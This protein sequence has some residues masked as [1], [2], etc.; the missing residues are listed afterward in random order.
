[1]TQCVKLRA[2]SLIDGRR[3]APIKKVRPTHTLRFASPA[4]IRFGETAINASKMQL[5]IFVCALVFCAN[6]LLAAV[7]RE[8]APRLAKI[9]IFDLD[10]TL[11]H[12]STQVDRCFTLAIASF[13][14]CHSH[15]P[16]DNWVL[17]ATRFLTETLPR[18]NDAFFD[19]FYA[20]IADPRAFDAEQRKRLHRLLAQAA[21]VQF[22]AD[23]VAAFRDVAQRSD[24]SIWLFTNQCHAY[25]RSVLSSLGILPFFHG[26]YC[27]DFTNATSYKKPHPKSYEAMRQVLELYYDLTSAECVFFEDSPKNLQTAK[28]LYNWRTV[29][30]TEFRKHDA[31][32][33]GTQEA[34]I[35]E[36]DIDFVLEDITKLHT[37]IREDE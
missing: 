25:A 31:K 17:K 33:K 15:D 23:L 24:V 27:C 6:A 18:N 35:K 34:P 5:L 2:R 19:D 13:V 11:Y 12:F 3:F 22:R 10:N 29:L 16:T 4:K 1:M 21:D 32:E 30:V 20:F 36:E 26:V 28:K 8:N 37:I 7:V 9:L 14:R